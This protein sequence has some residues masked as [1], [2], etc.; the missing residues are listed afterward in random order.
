MR[1]I[2]IEKNAE[3][4]RLDKFLKRFLPLAGSGFLYRMLRKKNILL[5]GKRASG[6]EILQSGDKVRLY[7][8]DAT[9]AGFQEKA[10]NFSMLPALP[11]EWIIQETKDLLILNKP[12]G[13]LSQKAK[14]EDVSM[15]DYLRGYL[16]QRGELTT[17]SSLLYMP[18][19][20]NRLDRNT[21][22]L[23]LAAKN[24][25]A[26]QKWTDAIKRRNVQKYYLAIVH[27]QPENDQKLTAWIRKDSAS[28]RTVVLDHEEKGSKKIQMN[29]QRLASNREFSVLRIHLIT[30][31]SHQI[32]AHLSYLGYPI[33]GDRKYGKD[34]RDFP[35]RQ[36]LH[37]GWMDLREAFPC[38]MA[39]PEETES[40]TC[41]DTIYKERIPYGEDSLPELLR[42]P[43]PADMRAFMKKNHLQL[44]REESPAFP[45]S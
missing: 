21:S 30:G 5:N 40:A 41:V 27:G 20:L 16:Y 39:H 19:I 34:H 14:E 33:V 38:R 35:H 1:E 22:G 11:A 6:K 29:C 7:F 25:Q 15:V 26:A 32:R 28:N 2:R 17:K 36:L 18:G 43:I 23:L 13:I 8:S 37:A 12:A 31:R 10:T 9:I 45:E 4:Q 42:A 44:T 3:Q 24:L